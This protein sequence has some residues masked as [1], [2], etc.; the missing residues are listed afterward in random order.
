MKSVTVAIEISR[1]FVTV[2]DN[3]KPQIYA[4]LLSSSH[5]G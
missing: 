2:Y 1:G 3:G 4:V 5:I